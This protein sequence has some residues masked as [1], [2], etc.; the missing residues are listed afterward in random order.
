MVSEKPTAN[1][2]PDKTIIQGRSVV[3]EGSAT[4]QSL[5]YFWLPPLYMDNA[6]LLQPT[7]NPPLDISYTLTVTSTNGCG[8]A[9]DTMHVFVFKGI[10]I[11][12]AFSPNGDGLNDTWKIPAL[13][14]FPG[15]ELAVFNRFG[16]RVFENKNA[17]IP[18]D[19]NFKGVPLPAGA[20][21]YVIDLKQFPGIL[22]GAVLL[23]R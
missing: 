20:Y 5:N 18:W 22:K 8:T 21:V 16:Q 11:P 12:T 17:V 14:A 3:L 19:G 13:A 2:G 1:A 15:F 4:G 23:M 9:T 10:F 7:V 6:Q